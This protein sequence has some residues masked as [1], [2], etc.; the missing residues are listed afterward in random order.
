MISYDQNGRN[1]SVVRLVW[2]NLYISFQEA[3]Q[4]NDVKLIKMVSHIILGLPTVCR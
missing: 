3:K 1:I 2:T 4:N